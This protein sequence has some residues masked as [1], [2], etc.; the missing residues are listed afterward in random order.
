MEMILAHLKTPTLREIVHTAPYMRNGAL[1][2]LEETVDFYNKGGITNPFLDNELRRPGRTLE[3]VLEYYE[4]G[5]EERKAPPLGSILMRLDL[6][7]LERE[8]LVAFLKALSGQG[9]Q[10]IQPPASFPE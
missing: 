9:W 3:Q 6:S 10:Y 2:T 1:A 5:K 4:K 7:K 8:D